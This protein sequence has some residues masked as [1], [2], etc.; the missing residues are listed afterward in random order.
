M[1]GTVHASVALVGDRGVLIRGKSGS[2]KSSLLLALLS[3]GDATL[4]ADDRAHLSARDG[5][6]VAT[7]PDAIAG[8][9]EVR[10]VGIIRKPHAPSAAID[11]VV[12][13]LPLAECPRLPDAAEASVTL[14]G[15]VVPRVFIAIGGH[16]GVAR[17]AAA[18]GRTKAEIPA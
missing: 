11:L 9:M 13:L 4:V 10:G 1:S 2:G 17:V 3:A 14:E 12:D 18:L 6:L 7:V 16:D 15:I 5:R 8:Q